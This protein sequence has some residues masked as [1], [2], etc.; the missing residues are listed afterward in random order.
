[1]QQFIPSSK[2]SADVMALMDAL[3]RLDQD[4]MLSY[5]ALSRV[6]GRDVKSTYRYLLVAATD[7]LLKTKQKAFGTV[8]NAGIK[9]LTDSEAI[10]QCASTLGR[11]RRIAKK[12]A[13]KAATV[14]FA[15]LSNE[16]K[17][18]HNGYISQMAAIVYTAD[19]RHINR[20]TGACQNTNPSILPTAQVLNLLAA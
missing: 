19:S 6:V 1:M 9:R 17:L 13:T 11:V 8:T 20:I 14:N 16:E 3:D 18:R 5:E 15:A 10:S 7:R 2:N 12:A 4:A